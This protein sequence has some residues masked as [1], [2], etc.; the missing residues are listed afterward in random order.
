MNAAFNIAFELLEFVT[1]SRARRPYLRK[2]VIWK[3]GVIFWIPPK[4]CC[5]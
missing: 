3:A 1:A 2:T 5:K 4:L